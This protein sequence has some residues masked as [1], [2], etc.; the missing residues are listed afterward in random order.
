MMAL[1]QRNLSDPKY[2]SSSLQT[3]LLWKLLAAVLSLAPFVSPSN[4]EETSGTQKM[5]T[6]LKTLADAPEQW[7][8]VYS[9]DVR[10]QWFANALEQ[11][12]DSNDP[13]PDSKELIYLKY[14]YAEQLLHAGYSGR[15]AEELREIRDLMKMHRVILSWENMQAIHFNHALS[16]LRMGE[17]E[18]CI[19][20]HNRL[21]CVFPIRGDGVHRFQDGSRRALQLFTDYLMVNPDDFEARWLLNIAAMTIGNYPHE[22]PTRWLIAPERF[23]SE[24]GLPPFPDVAPELGL[25]VNG[26]AGG[27]IV[28]DFDGDSFLDV[29]VSSMGRFDNLRY[30]KNNGDGTFSERTV[31]AGLTGISGGLNIVHA[32]YNN[33]GFADVLVLRGGW[34]SEFDKLGE[35]PNSLLRNNGDGT[36]VDVTE[37]A[38]V[39]S[40]HPTQTAVWF[41]YDGNGW[42]DLFIGNES[43]STR[44]THPCELYRNNGDGT[45]TECAAKV[46]LDVK[47]FVKGA[48]SGDYNNDRLPDLYI[49]VYGESNLLFRNDGPALQKDDSGHRWTFSERGEVAG[50]AGPRQ[51]FPTWFWDYNNDGWEDLFVCGY[52][53]SGMAGAVADAMGIEHFAARMRLYRNNGNGT[54]TD[55]TIRVGLYRVA[56][57]MGANYGDL[58]NDG[59]LDFYIGT[60]N[61]D[62]ATLVP[63]RMFRS[64]EGKLFQDVTTVGGFGHLQKGHGVSF[65]DLDH[66][67]DQDIYAVIGGAYTGDVYTN[68]LYG[69]PGNGNRWI[70]LS[71]LGQKTNRLAL[72]ARIKMIVS[73]GRVDR[74]IHRTV[75][76]GGSFGAS[77]FRQEIGLGK[78]DEIRRVEVLWPVSGQRQT[79]RNLESNH[80]YVLR[81][82]ETEATPWPLKDMM[83]QAEREKIEH[84]HPH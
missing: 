9:N 67:G 73:D 84:R 38:G 44:I 75:S 49:S 59:W 57:G 17:Q 33:D 58:D 78:A 60:G 16:Y 35:L 46:G 3:R 68:V 53:F 81:E 55:V 7:K 62:L 64:S 43:I 63:N 30:F 37:S 40:F 23:D 70:K 15:A 66:D 31:E 65:A 4:A 34:F 39:L 32:D 61:P 51:S 25:D 41:D 45:F 56:L 19:Q 72:G 6:L 14:Q 42:L 2:S 11:A 83:F 21:S 71:L 28:E 74:E 77:P 80:G 22:I 48:V 18:N 13:P 79:F 50:V 26:L 47:K 36:F 24:Y 5:V 52:G 29:M 82:G 12:A 10:T 69:N 8:N 20:D 27:S 54:F 76:A 1:Y